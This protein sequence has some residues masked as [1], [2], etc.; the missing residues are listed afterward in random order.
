MSAEVA[1][2]PGNAADRASRYATADSCPIFVQHLTKTY[3]KAHALDD[4]SL[5]VRRGEF[6]TLLGPSGSGK[7]TLLMAMAGF[8]RPSSGTICF[9]EDDVTRLPPHKRNVGVVFQNYALFPHMNVF[10]NVT[11]PL[12][13]RRVPKEEVQRRGEEALHLVDLNG[14]EKREV[15]QLSGGQRQRVA[16]A[17]AIV[18]KPRILLMDEPLSALDKKLRDRMQI[19]IRRLHDQLGMTTV[20]VTHDQREALIMSDRVAVINHGRLEQVDPPQTLYERP[21]NRFVAD[22]VGES[23]FLDVVVRGGIALLNGQKLETAQPPPSDGAYQLLVRPEK[24]TLISDTVSEPLNV[25]RGTVTQG[26]FQGESF[27]L[28][29]S[30]EGAQL[31]LRGLNRRAETYGA[32]REGEMVTL[33]LHPNDTIL[34]PDEGND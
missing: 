34:I 29:V 30:V 4:V 7:T 28:Y 12:R 15:E 5:E 13:L 10:G 9:G 24:L 31:A 19:E 2:E 18:F 26:V 27:I 33:G 25:L 6:L 14:Y 23:Y 21:T 11:Y 32:P 20:Y 3:G 22:F 16:I 17:R 1:S 8:A